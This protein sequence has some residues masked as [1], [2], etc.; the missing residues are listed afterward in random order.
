MSNEEE[1]NSLAKK[2]ERMN[3]LSC[4][5]QPQNTQKKEAHMEQLQDIYFVVV[6]RH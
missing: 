2:K 6:D 1:N 4:T 3:M 5:C